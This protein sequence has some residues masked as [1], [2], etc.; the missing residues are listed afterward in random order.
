MD[1]K[2]KNANER[3]TVISPNG[4]VYYLFPLPE[5]NIEDVPEDCCLQLNLTLTSNGGES[6]H[7]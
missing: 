5:F 6:K 1:L 3:N 4:L 2:P 7:E